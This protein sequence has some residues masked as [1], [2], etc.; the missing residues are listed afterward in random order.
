MWGKESY[1]YISGEIIKKS[2]QEAH[3]VLNRNCLGLLPWQTFTTC[4]N[5]YLQGCSLNTLFNKT[6][7]KIQLPPNNWLPHAGEWWY[8]AVKIIEINL[9]VLIWLNLKNIMLDKNKSCR[10]LHVVW[11]HRY[12]KC[13]NVKWQYSFTYI[14]HIFSTHRNATYQL[15]VCGCL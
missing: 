6:S 3:T 9:L 13:S 12:K 14:Q 8:I 10:N 4:T 15:Q 1:L 7:E 5:K 2:K 11:K